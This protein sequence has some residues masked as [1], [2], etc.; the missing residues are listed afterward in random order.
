MHENEYTMTPAEAEALGPNAKKNRPKIKP[1]LLPTLKNV[2]K[3][4]VYE[5]SYKDVEEFLRSCF[6]WLDKDFSIIT[7]E[8]WSNDSDHTFVVRKQLSDYEINQINRIKNGESR[9]EMYSTGTLLNKACADGFLKPG[10]YL[11]TVCW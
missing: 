5:V 1:K 9:F 10:E 11:I 7:N 2:K 4:M 6:P 3:I 8:E